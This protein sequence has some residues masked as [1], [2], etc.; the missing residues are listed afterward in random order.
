M[1]LAAV[2]TTITV[3]AQ[4]IS[5]AKDQA[6]KNGESLKS[7]LERAIVNQLETEGDFETRY[8][9]NREEESGQFD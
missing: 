5:D 2:R 3:D 8:A 6:K 9:V 4:A 1:K 7:F